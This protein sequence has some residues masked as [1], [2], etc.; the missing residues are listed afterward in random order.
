M[1]QIA[2]PQ[3]RQNPLLWAAVLLATALLGLLPLAVA[4]PGP[5]GSSAAPPAEFDRVRVAYFEFGRTVDTLVLV[6]P[7]S[8]QRLRSLTLEHA[9]EYGV[10]PGLSPD[11]RRVAYNLL[12]PETRVP[13]PDA[14]AQLWVADIASAEARLAASDVDLLVAPLWSPDGGGLVFR[15]SSAGEGP[16]EL[17]LAGTAAGSERSLIASDA[18]LFPIAF[19]PDGG[20]L[21]FAALTE[22]GSTLYRLSAAGGPPDA[23]AQLS[24]GLTRDWALSPDGSRLAYLE[25]TLEGRDASSRAF[26]LDLKTGERTPAG[27]PGANAFNPRWDAAGR[28]YVGQLAGSIPGGIAV[29]GPGSQ[30]SLTPP[31]R[32]FDVPL[33][34]HPEAGAAVTSFDA[35]SVL[36]PGRATLVVIGADGAR[37]PITSREVTFLGWITP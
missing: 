7:H 11:G 36:N 35:P 28:L 8:S 15:R 17:L 13:G 18:A 34:V 1:V 26:V 32:G 24:S 20:A 14:P 30:T 19:S 3:P 33:A 5:G 22:Y 4:R 21:Y 2:V 25:M 23:M 37:H 16:H 6:D 31:D 9:P 27:Q 10:V 29:T 12:P